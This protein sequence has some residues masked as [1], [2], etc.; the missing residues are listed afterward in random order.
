MLT[1]GVSIVAGVTGGVS[2]VAGVT[3][4]TG[5]VSMVA[6]VTMVTGGVSM[7]AGVNMVT[8]DV[9]MVAGV[10]GGVFLVMGVPGGVSMVT[11]VT[12]I[13][14]ISVDGWVRAAVL[15]PPVGMLPFWCA[16]LVLVLTGVGS[17]LVDAI[18]PLGRESIAAA[19]EVGRHEA[20][21]DLGIKLTGLSGFPSPAKQVVDTLCSAAAN[22][23]RK[24]VSP[25]SPPLA[26]AAAGLL[27]FAVS[28]I[29][30]SLRR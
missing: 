19:V 15:P 26:P 10:P 23:V 4:V 30:L 7:V 2:M 13:I 28:S 1:S 8:G 6:G 21:G 3:M 16:G 20:L 18:T 25:L 24:F 12:I 29:M 11:G 27:P 22:G 5:G 14:G 9:S 17:L